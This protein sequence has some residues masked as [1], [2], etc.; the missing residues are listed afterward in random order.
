[1]K[2]GRWPHFL[3]I[4]FLLTVLAGVRSA[5][6]YGAS[7]DM[8]IKVQTEEQKLTASALDKAELNKAYLKG[9]YTDTVHIL[10]STARWEKADWFTAAAVV[11]TVAGV[12]AYDQDLQEWMQGKRNNTTNR[13]SDVFRPF[14]NIL[15]T[16]PAL[17]VFYGY[18]HAAEDQKARRTALFG[19][20]SVVISSLFTQAL[21]YS[22]HRRRPSDGNR[23]DQWDGP[24]FSGSDISFPSEHAAS[25]FALATVIAD[26][27]R[28]SVFV[29]P[30]VYGVATMASLSKVND[31]DHWC[32]DIFLGA[33]IGYLT[34]KTIMALHKSKSKIEIIPGTDGKRATLSLGVPF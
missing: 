3:L 9:Y 21:K 33:A 12:Y 10:T 18:G 20:E 1:M 15:Y 34:A 23:Y 29:A 6:V 24:S 13:L 27:Y 31:N 11:G 28:D 22:T 5:P 14:G 32:S 17:G 4:A 7:D 8:L 25:A 30:V 2:I 16:I 19:V 26:E